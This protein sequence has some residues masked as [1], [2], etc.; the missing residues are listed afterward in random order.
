MNVITRKDNLALHLNAARDIYPIEYNFYPQ[1]WVLPRDSSSLKRQFNKKRAKTFIVKPEAS[2]QG[3]GIF[4]TRHI[5]E[6]PER[7][8]VQRY[9]HKPM[10]L[11]GLKFD[12]RLYVLV[13]G[14]DPLRIYLHK[15]GL[16]R[17]ATQPYTPPKP[18]NLSDAWR[19]LTNYAIN[20]NNPGFIY[21]T[22]S[23]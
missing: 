5:E 19:H 10:L 11:D 2:C 20:K 6:I 22:S 16:V 12:L 14:C 3:R 15:E 13:S 8:V 21:N 7:C 17:L 9:V 18:S 4:L 1:T 23:D